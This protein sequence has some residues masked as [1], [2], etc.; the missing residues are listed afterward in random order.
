MARRRR[1]RLPRETAGVIVLDSGAIAK[2]A[3]RGDPVARAVWR[4]LTERG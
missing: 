4:Q 3:D 1:V 2:L